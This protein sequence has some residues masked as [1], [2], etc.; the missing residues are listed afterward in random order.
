MVNVFAEGNSV[1]VAIGGEIIQQNLPKLSLFPGNEIVVRINSFGGDFHFGREIYNWIIA[2]KRN[3]RC[4]VF[5]AVSAATIPMMAC[6]EISVS[7]V[8]VVMVH[9]VTATAEINEHNATE[10]VS[11]IETFNSILANLYALRSSE[12]ADYFRRIMLEEKILNAEDVQ[13]IFNATIL[14]N[15]E[16]MRMNEEIAFTNVAFRNS[17]RKKEILYRRFCECLKK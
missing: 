7:P 11:E 2:D 17:C 15:A 4:E 16:R 5:N 13:R 1:V 12:S 9:G 3:K 10:M 6:D 8:A 14:Q